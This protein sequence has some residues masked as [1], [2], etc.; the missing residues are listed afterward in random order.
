MINW[1]RIQNPGFALAHEGLLRKVENFQILENV[2]HPGEKLRGTVQAIG[3]K[4]VGQV[5]VYQC[6]W[7]WST[8]EFRG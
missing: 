2:I 4:E 3:W 6:L 8:Q 7:K 1:S 5:Y